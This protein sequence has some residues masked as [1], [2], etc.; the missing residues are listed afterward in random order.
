MK[1]KEKL[2]NLILSS[3][4]H[5]KGKLSV[6]KMMWTTSLALLFPILGGIY[7]FGIRVLYLVL[8]CVGFSVILELLCQRL[9]GI[10]MDISDGSAVVTGILLALIVPPSFPLWAAI[11]GVAFSICIVKHI[12]GG[13][14]KNIFNPALMGRA[15]LVAAF[16]ILITTYVIN[17]RGYIAESPLPAECQISVDAVTQ[18]TPLSRIKFEGKIFAPENYFLKFFLGEKK[19]SS[20]ETVAILILVGLFILIITKVADW[21]L[22]FSYFAAVFIFST[23]L[24]FIN[25]DIYINPLLSLFLGG[26]MFGGTYMVTDPVTTPLSKKGKWIFGLGAGILTVIIRNYSGYPEGVMFSILL[27]NAVTPLINR[28]TAPKIYGT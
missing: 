3:A 4:P 17:Y 28:W 12:F 9:R 19:G 11:L 27:M 22:P 13:F 10:K 26:V 23:V 20:G 25:S 16:P 6:N 2:N 5:I 7:F 18:A 15:F 1:E 24:W 8:T 14:G 21:R